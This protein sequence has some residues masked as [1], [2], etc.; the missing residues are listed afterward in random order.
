M[1]SDLFQPQLF[2]DERCIEDSAFV[3]R[4]WHQPLKFPEP[5]LKAENAWEQWCPVIYGTV[6]RW[7]GLFRMWYGV[8]TRRD[9]PCVC[10]AQSE[11]GVA[12]EKPSLGLHEFGR[13][14]N[15]NIVLQSQYSGGFID[16]LTV[17][18]DAEDKEWPLKALLWDGEGETFGIHAA[19][20]KDGLQWDRSPGLVLPN[21]GDRF[22]AAS[23]KINGKYLVFGRA[24]RNLP[25][26]H[27][28]A[29]GGERW[30]V[31][32]GRTVWR[33]ESSDL[34]E[35]SE[36]RLV[37]ASD[38]HDPMH[39]EYYSCVPFPYGSLLLAGLERMHY[40][41]DM[42]DTEIIWSYDDGREWQRANTRPCFLP[43]STPRAWDDTWINLP[44]NAPIEN[45][46]ALWFYYSGRSSAHDSHYPHNHGAIGLA[47]LRLDGFASLQALDKI[48]YVLT[49]VL[50]WPDADLYLNCDPRRDIAAHPKSGLGE[51]AVEVR[52]ESNKV[53]PGFSWNECETLRANTSYEERS[54]APVRWKNEKSV[55]ALAGRKIR[56]AFRLRDCHLY[57]FRAL[58][59]P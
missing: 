40:S 29:Q 22:N 58:R 11:D 53:L 43:L 36:P 25:A 9:K 21:W 48:G 49:R 45:E 59:K 20:S 18:D 8:W 31:A 42:V 7:R 13:S 1:K 54:V 5:I 24:P 32:K 38:V 10:Y 26:T 27:L 12:W 47:T 56:F 34:K 39:R 2:L 23:T 51:L 35:W 3:T 50:D 37:L 28:T 30:R 16:D 17:I 46:G 55:R 6:L 52:D 19:R 14:K 57:S 44:A 15:N 4:R 33:I 41:P